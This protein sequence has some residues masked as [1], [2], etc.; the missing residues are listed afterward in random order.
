M[1][2]F[3]EK[4]SLWPSQFNR[5]SISIGIDP[6]VGHLT[7][8]LKQEWHRLDPQEFLSRL[9]CLGVEL[10]V[11]RKCSVKLQS[12][13]FEACGLQG[14]AALKEICDFAN[15]RRVGLILDVKRGDIASTMQAYANAA[16]AYFGADTITVL[17]FMGLSCLE[18]LIDWLSQGKGVFVVW[19]SSNPDAR[20]LQEPIEELLLDQIIDFKR[21]HCLDK[22]IGLV[23]GATCASD[24]A[25][26][27]GERMKE[28]D[29]LLP[30]LG[31]QG[32]NLDQSLIAQLASTDHNRIF[33]ISRGLFGIGLEDQLSQLSG[34]NSWEAYGSYVGTRY[35]NYVEQLRQLISHA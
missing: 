13:F 2:V 21:R 22:Q 25:K 4:L 29:L 1:T 3:R 33:P 5:F 28:F 23:V 26:R 6:H 19:R 18:A 34:V 17:P 9:G 16:Y 14:I 10:A 11:E 30:G 20:T 35:T 32:A 15:Q 24:L 8:F 7:G 31:A 27:H 12:A